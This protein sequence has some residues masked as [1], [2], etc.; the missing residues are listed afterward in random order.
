MTRHIFKLVWNR[1]RSTGLI[2]TEILLSFL[3]LCA[4]LVSTTNVYQ[5]WNSPQGFD[6]HDVW[7]VHIIG[8]NYDSKNVWRKSYMKSQADLLRMIKSMPEVDSGATS[9][10]TPFSDSTWRDDTY[11]DGQYTPVLFNLVSSEFP[12]VLKLELL[13]GRWHNESDAALDYKAVLISRSLAEALF[14]LDDP[15]GIIFVASFPGELYLF[16]CRCYFGYQYWNRPA[17]Q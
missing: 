13:N 12:K 10:N 8:M 9:S 6:F 5:Q 7:A 17:G 3:V 15:V 2:L 4:I 1:K 16:S 11:I 14:G